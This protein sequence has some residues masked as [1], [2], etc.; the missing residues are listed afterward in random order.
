[1]GYALW[2]V[3]AVVMAFV[4]A[5]SLGLFTM[6]F[7]VGAL[8]ALVAQILGFDLFTQI[9]VFLVVSVVLL[10]SLRPYAL[11]H[12]N[13]GE[14]AEPSMVGQS[15]RVIVDIP[16][17]GTPGRVETADRMTWAA[18]S[19]TGEAIEFGARVHIVG[20]ESIKLIVE[21]TK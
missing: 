7:V 18:L 10:V 16:A 2:I 20:Q 6:W 17:D 4:E 5:L 21:R 15:A 12:R 9:V 11:K 13:R 1:M 14:A 8:A 19:A 3:I